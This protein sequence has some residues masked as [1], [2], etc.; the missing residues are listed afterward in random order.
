MN[1]LLNITFQGRQH[2]HS[3]ELDPAVDDQTICRVSEEVASLP[4]GSLSNF[5]VD[6]IEDRYV[7]RPKVPFGS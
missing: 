6:R 3:V 2:N 5:V 1:I 4:Q 7:V